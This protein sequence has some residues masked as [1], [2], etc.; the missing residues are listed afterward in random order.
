MTG[1]LELFA[2]LEMGSGVAFLVRWRKRL[3]TDKVNYFVSD[4]RTHVARRH[5]DA[6]FLPVPSPPPPTF[7]SLPKFFF[8]LLLFFFFFPFLSYS[9]PPS[10]KLLPPPPAAPFRARGKF[11]FLVEKSG[12][13]WNGIF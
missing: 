4:R 12:M 11:L 9:F 7:P 13:E 5:R 3:L 8:F 6:C 10:Y 2:L 1:I